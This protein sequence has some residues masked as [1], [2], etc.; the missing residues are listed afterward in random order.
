ME[1]FSDA[2]YRTLLK[3]GYHVMA[4]RV[5]EA[6][7]PSNS[8]MEGESPVRSYAFDY[9]R[10]PDLSQCKGD[11]FALF[12]GEISRKK[13]DSLFATDRAS[14][15]SMSISTN[16]KKARNECSGFLPDG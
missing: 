13:A 15:W 11:C 5:P 12:G 7:A 1:C 16:N 2:D 10:C 8:P 14:D 6:K 4:S 9:R 3:K